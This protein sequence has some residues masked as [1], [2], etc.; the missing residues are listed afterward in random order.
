M[1]ASL[2]QIAV[3]PDESVEDRRVRAAS[4]V[5]AQQGADLVVLPELWPVG[6]FAYT[7]F[8]AEAELLE[9]PTH[10]VMAKAAAEAGT[11]LHMR[12][13]RRTGGRRH[14]VQHQPGLLAPG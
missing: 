6:A 1:R 9:G 8:E 11:W 12:L 5:V 14:P 4:L 10:E 3:D 2:I 13:L 7:A